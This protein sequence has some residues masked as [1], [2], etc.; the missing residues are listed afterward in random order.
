MD[1]GRLQSGSRRAQTWLRA[2]ILI[3]GTVTT[4][5]FVALSPILRTLTKNDRTGS[6][7]RIGVGIVEQIVPPHMEENTKPIPAQVWVRV[8]GTLTAAETVFGSAQLRVG[9]PAQ[10]TYRIGRS[11]RLYV[12]RVEPMPSPSPPAHS[13]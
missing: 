11:G 2:A 6:P 8:N 12:D 1:G 13:K 9:G 7:A 4:L 3:I 5:C 10:V